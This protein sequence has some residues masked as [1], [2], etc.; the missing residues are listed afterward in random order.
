[1]WI[2]SLFCLSG[3]KFFHVLQH[4]AGIWVGRTAENIEREKQSHDNL[5]GFKPLTSTTESQ[6]LPKDIFLLAWNLTTFTGILHQAAD[7]QGVRLPGRG[8][9][10]QNSLGG[11][12]HGQVQNWI[13]WLGRN[14]PEVA[15]AEAAGLAEQV[16]VQEG[17]LEPMPVSQVWTFVAQL[18]GQLDIQ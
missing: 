1:M 12:D 7:H 6:L 18:W 9:E 17:V 5:S 10:I 16:P 3:I 15:E 13:V 8:T 2:S 14:G 4:A 11:L